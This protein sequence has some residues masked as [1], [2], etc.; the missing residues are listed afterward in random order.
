V[1]YTSKEQGNV[2]DYQK[3]LK[4]KCVW[5]NLTEAVANRSEEARIEFVGGCDHH[6][7]IGRA[8][9][10]PPTALS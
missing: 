2:S 6:N 7:V 5:A 10:K 4:M 9:S 3:Q 8:G 1:K